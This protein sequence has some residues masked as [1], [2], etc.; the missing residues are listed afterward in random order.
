MSPDMILHL[1]SSLGENFDSK[2]F[3]WKKEIEDKQSDVQV[4]HLLTEIA[5]KQLPKL[6][7]DEMDLDVV[8]DLSEET[9]KDYISY[10]PEVL[11]TVT[12]VTCMESE[13]TQQA[14]TGPSSLMKFSNVSQRITRDWISHTLS[15]FFCVLFVT[16]LETYLYMG[17]V[18]K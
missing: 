3:S 7:D 12:Q 14:F 4:S 10:K 8:L 5:E 13:K 11:S 16:I 15:K 18:E 9:V 17:Q 6:E 2:V 1:Q